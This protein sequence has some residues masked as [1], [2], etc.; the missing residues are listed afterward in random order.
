MSAKLPYIQFYTGDW[1]KDPVL[2]RCTKAEKG[3]MIDALCILHENED[4][5]VFSTGGNAW[6]REEIAYAVGG[7]AA[8]N[9]SLLDSV[10][11]KGGLKLNDSG[12]I[13]SKRMVRDEEIR[14]IRSKS[15]SK[16]G[17]KTQAKF[18]QR[19]KQNSED[20]NDIEV[21]EEKERGVGENKKRPP[22]Q[23]SCVEYCKSLDL[24]E[25]DGAWLWEKWEGNGFRVNGKAMKSWK[26]TASAWKRAGYFPSQ[27]GHLE[28]TKGIGKP[29]RK[30]MWELK[31]Q[32]EA[33]E[34]ELRDLRFPGGCSFPKALE[35][36]ALDHA[37]KLNNTIKKLKREIEEYGDAA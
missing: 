11:R 31:Q 9:L 6:S 14:R 36:E 23:S 35:G 16:G 30:T 4:R 32:L 13:Y 15:G 17:S 29:K 34:N 37:N 25:N 7:D 1:L 24:T 12:A 33:C 8:E 2:R 19:E 10:L 28:P 26:S 22:D 27:K 20:E 18:K 3:F 5:G 21:I